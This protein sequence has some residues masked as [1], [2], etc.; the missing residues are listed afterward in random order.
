LVVQTPRPRII[1]VA[2]PPM[3]KFADVRGVQVSSLGSQDM[4]VLRHEV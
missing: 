1:I 2:V 3:K 4:V